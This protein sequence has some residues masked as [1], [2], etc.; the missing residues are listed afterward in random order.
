MNTE[1]LA[2][3]KRTGGVLVEKAHTATLRSCL[4]PVLHFGDSTA[5]YHAGCHATSL[6][7]VSD[8]TLIEVTG[9]DAASFVH[10]FCTNDINKLQ[11][12]EGC[13]A[14]LTNI[15]GKI[16]AHIFVFK[17]DTSLW[18]ETTPGMSDL[19]CTHLDRYLFSEDVEFHS[20]VEDVGE[21][22]LT[23][24]SSADLLNNI[25]GAEQSLGLMEH[26]NITCQG[27]DLTLRRVDFFSQPGF[28]LSAKRDD[29]VA[30]W[31]QIVAAGAVASGAEAFHA[32]RI[33][34]QFPLYGLDLTDDNLAQEAARTPAAISFTKGCYLGQEP[35]ARI[36]AVGH[37]NRE[38]Q[39]IDIATRDAPTEGNAIKTDTGESVGTI[40]SAASIPG[41]QRSVAICMLKRGHPAANSALLVGDAQATPRTSV[42]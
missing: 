5:E 3:Q 2:E 7:D 31:Q 9:G 14:F 30:I 23:G 1:I 32:L 13:E 12:G 21:L 6:F 24:P 36:D 40:S 39:A 20:R 8:R 35:I 38:L 10:N 37:V 19:I 41:E 25:S 27:A 42:V 22:F 17:T 29:L 4:P 34:A 18:I 11:S 16:L 26:R 28:L 15:Q 33:E